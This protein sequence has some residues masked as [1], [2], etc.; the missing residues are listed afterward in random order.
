MSA[1]GR[2]ARHL[3][4]SAG[5]PVVL[6][7][8]AEAA[9]ELAPVAAVSAAPGRPEGYDAI[10]GPALPAEVPG[11]AAQLRP[12]GRLILTASDPPEALLAAL[13]QAGL[14]HCLVEVGSSPE[15]GDAAAGTPAH[16]Y[17]GERPPRVP[18]GERVARV[19]AQPASA[20]TPYLFLLITQ[21]PNVPGW[22]L[23][24]GSSVRWQ[25]AT[26]LHPAT[27][28]LRLLAFSSLA[29]AVAFMQPAIRAGAIGGVNKIAKYPAGA[30][31]HWLQPVWLNPS[32]AEAL[33]AAPGPAL[34]VDPAI[35][36]TGEE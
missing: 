10:A 23:P 26:R 17:R 36:I 28:Q 20:A 15:P 19:A 12:G 3:P 22:R 4:P 34:E 9:A 29:R 6:A 31:E 2:S 21:T 18:P 35:A 7:L 30:A 33:A 25:A 32:P 5:L 13:T 14:I 16:L 11:L 27:G 8:S 1:P 24:A